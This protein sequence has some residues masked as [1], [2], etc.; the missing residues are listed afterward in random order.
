MRAVPTITIYSSSNGTSG[1][2]R[3]GDAGADLTVGT[4]NAST[5]SFHVENSATVTDGEQIAWT[6]KLE[7]EL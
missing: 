5:S 3:R 6:W 2:A 4:A 1:K 7:S